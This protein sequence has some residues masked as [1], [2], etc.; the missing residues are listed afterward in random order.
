MKSHWRVHRATLWH[1]ECKERLLNRSA[2][3]WILR[4]ITSQKSESLKSRNAWWRLSAHCVTEFCICYLLSR[5]LHCLRTE[6]HYK[7]RAVIV[8]CPRVY[9][10][11]PRI[12]ITVSAHNAHNASREIKT[13]LILFRHQWTQCVPFMSDSDILHC[14][15]PGYY[16]YWNLLLLH[17]NGTTIE[18]NLLLGH[19]RKLPVIVV[20]GSVNKLL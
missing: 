3:F 1:F 18:R 15:P 6:H 19:G 13:A 4:C 20:E 16:V 14:D 2:L 7:W 17:S 11:L 12:L 9:M 8:L 10:P 5:S